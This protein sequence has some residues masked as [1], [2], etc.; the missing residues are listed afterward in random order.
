MRREDT[1]AAE[2]SSDDRRWLSPKEAAAYISGGVDAIYDA[3]AERRLRS[4]KLGHS[5]IRIKREW[6]DAWMESRVQ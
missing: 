2:T 5:T 6:L 1:R 3:C 4:V